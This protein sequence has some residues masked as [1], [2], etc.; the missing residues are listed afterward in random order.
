VAVGV[1][2]GFCEGITLGIAVALGTVVGEGDGAG[3][4]DGEVVGVFSCSPLRFSA[5][6]RGNDIKQTA[7]PENFIFVFSNN[8]KYK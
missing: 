7:I 5:A 1:S 4:S 6:T 8:K 3:L 2:V